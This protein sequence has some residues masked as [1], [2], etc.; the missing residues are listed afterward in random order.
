MLK[1][2]LAFPLNQSCHLS[3][4]HVLGIVSYKVADNPFVS[5][6]KISIYGILLESG[7]RI[8]HD[9][10][11]FGVF[12]CVCVFGSFPFA[13]SQKIPSSSSVPLGSCL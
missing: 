6:D 5:V 9:A 3:C 10:H 12:L 7:M 13:S 4:C 2:T 8:T 1:F 11:A